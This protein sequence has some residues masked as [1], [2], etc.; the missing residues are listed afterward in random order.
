[1]D[2]GARRAAPYPAPR[3]ET[4][5]KHDTVVEA[6]QFGWELR[7]TQIN[8]R[9]LQQW[10]S[11]GNRWGQQPVFADR[12]QAIEWMYGWVRHRGWMG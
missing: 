8:G 4:V 2:L 9:W 11:H 7:R 5:R 3:Q 10:H 1:M 12:E 6:R